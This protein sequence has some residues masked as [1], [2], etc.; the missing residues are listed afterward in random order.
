MQVQNVR[1]VTVMFL[2]VEI[3][4]VVFAAE[5]SDEADGFCLVV[6]NDVGGV[7]LR[8]CACALAPDDCFA[9]IEEGANVSECYADAD[10]VVGCFAFGA[11]V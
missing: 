4:I 2:P 1:S 7:A 10:T 8:L 3:R 5:S 9:C 11:F 6:G